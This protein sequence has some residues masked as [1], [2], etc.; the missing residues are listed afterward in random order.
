MECTNKA[1][2]FLR[3]L[4]NEIIESIPNTI[5]VISV[6]DTVPKGIEAKNCIC[7]GERMKAKEVINLAHSIGVNH[8]IQSPP[9]GRSQELIIATKMITQ[10]KHFINDP[11]TQILG[12]QKK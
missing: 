8:I 6:H 10:P 7:I 4:P 11:V 5:F 9:E 3:K 12:V 1:S 2:V